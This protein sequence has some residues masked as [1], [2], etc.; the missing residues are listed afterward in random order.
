M[1]T[2][3]KHNILFL[4]GF[5][6]SGECEIAR[7]LKAELVGVS[8]V[9]APDLPLHPFETMDMLLDLCCGQ[10]FDL[11]VGSSCGA[12]YSQQ[13][14][15]F[16]GVPAILVSPVFRMTEFLSQRIGT[17][18]YKSP[19]ADGK[20]Q[21][22]IDAQ[23]ISEFARMQEHQFDCYDEFNRDRVI[24]MFGS[25]DTLADTSGNKTYPRAIFPSLQRRKVSLVAHRQRLGIA[26]SNGRLSGPVRATRLLGACRT[27]VL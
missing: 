24:G 13:L 22:V 5:T 10:Q 8:E 4:H 21:F 1:T 11:I 3:N 27:D 9:V 18:E 15:R 2:G 6:S 7:M 20:Q 19:R 23:L 25:R 12:F 16:T 17:H 14:V 26:P